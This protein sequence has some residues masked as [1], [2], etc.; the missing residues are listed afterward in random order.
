M[1]CII[2][3]WY[4]KFCH[5]ITDS[6]CLGKYYSI[7]V[8]VCFKG[9]NLCIFRCQRVKTEHHCLCTSTTSFCC[10]LV[11]RTICRYREFLCCIFVNSMTCWSWN[12]FEV[13][14]S[15]FYIFKCHITIFIRYL[16]AYQ[17]VAAFTT[18]YFIQCISCS[19]KRI[20]TAVFR[21][22]LYAY[23]DWII[24]IYKCRLFCRCIIFKI[25]NGRLKIS[26]CIILCY[27][28]IDLDFSVIISNLSRIWRNQFFNCVIIISNF[29]K[30]N[31]IKEYRTI[32]CIF[33]SINQVIILIKQLECKFSRLKFSII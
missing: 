5:F 2:Q 10:Q 3:F 6:R 15:W 32:V 33:L 24:Y 4:T 19:L 20:F 22:L 11:N 17:N 23:A 21:S 25:S 30:Y 28:Y 16:C 14:S 31:G 27:T 7:F 12:F 26:C 13:I 1:I 9:T 8:I 18:K 29:I